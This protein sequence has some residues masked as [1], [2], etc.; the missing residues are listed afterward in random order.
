M[1]AKATHIDLFCLW[2]CEDPLGVQRVNEGRRGVQVPQE[3]LET[4]VQGVSLL[5]VHGGGVGTTG[6]GLVSTPQVKCLPVV[7]QPSRCW[8]WHH[9][10][11]TG[12]NSSG[13]MFA[14]CRPI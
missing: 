2:F 1:K 6:G 11:N 7:G 3:A 10:W 14:C 5:L 4:L 13:E 12:V 9:W 8:S